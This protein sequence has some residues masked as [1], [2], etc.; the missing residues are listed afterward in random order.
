MFGM[1]AY[2]P[3]LGLVTSP[4]TESVFAIAVQTWKHVY[5]WIVFK[6]MER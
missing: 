5:T 2:W 6:A 4:V 1:E 3:L